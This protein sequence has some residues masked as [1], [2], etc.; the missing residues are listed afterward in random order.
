MS[1]SRSDHLYAYVQDV[2]GE[3]ETYGRAAQL[4]GDAPPD[5]MVVRVA[6][7]TP[8]GYRVIEVW[9]SRTMWEAFRDRR[10]RPTMR[11]LGGDGSDSVSNFQDMTVRHAVFSP[12]WLLLPKRSR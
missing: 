5:G 4:L 7:S 1:V 9:N 3:W 2:T 10:L 8:V 6:G 11:T 12:D